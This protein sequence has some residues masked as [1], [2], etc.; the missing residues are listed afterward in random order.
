MQN[1]IKGRTP[2]SLHPLI[3]QWQS[4]CYHRHLQPK[5]RKNYD[6]L[7]DGHYLGEECFEY[8]NF[9]LRGC[10]CLSHPS[11]WDRVRGCCSFSKLWINSLLACMPY[12]ASLRHT[13]AFFLSQTGL[14]FIWGKHALACMCMCMCVLVHVYRIDGN[15]LEL[16][17][18]FQLNWGGVSL[19]SL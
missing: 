14:H 15:V 18:T 9:T 8:Q 16:V 5:K 1:V 11:W 12:D 10:K 19:V 4:Y 3:P 13:V 7:Q 6:T 17:S 2:E